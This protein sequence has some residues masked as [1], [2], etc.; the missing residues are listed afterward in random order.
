MLNL[1]STYLPLL[2]RF[3][4]CTKYGWPW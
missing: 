3:E 1:H 4:I 2:A